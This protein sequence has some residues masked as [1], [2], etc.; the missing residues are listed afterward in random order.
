MKY[1]SHV[2]VISTLFLF[3][4]VNQERLSHTSIPAISIGGLNNRPIIALSVKKE[5]FDENK[6]DSGEIKIF[7]LHEGN[8]EIDTAKLTTESLG[9]YPVLSATPKGPWFLH[10]IDTFGTTAITKKGSSI[11]LRKKYYDGALAY[12]ENGKP[13]MALTD[14]NGRLS[15][16]KFSNNNE[17]RTTYTFAKEG[18]VGPILLATNG[19]TI[20]AA[21]RH[22]HGFK[23]KITIFVGTPDGRG[24]I[25]ENFSTGLPKAL[26]YDG[27]TTRIISTYAVG[28]GTETIIATNAKIKNGPYFYH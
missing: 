19:K 24:K 15:F 20:A 18:I 10:S 1:A 8:S 27:K 9:S 22:G 7:S 12:L 17:V 21:W 23:Q 14:K 13:I 4:C 28:I 16:L 25:T 26:F 3:G 2:L 5:S 11:R 6:L